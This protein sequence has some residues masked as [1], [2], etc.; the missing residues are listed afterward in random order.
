MIKS[1]LSGAELSAR[2]SFSVLCYLPQRWRVIRIL[3]QVNFLTLQMGK[4][5]PERGR[6]LPKTPQ[7]IQ[8][9]NPDFPTPRKLKGVRRG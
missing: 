8:S 1:Y 7:L 6:E 5:R 2:L 3:R 9:S 4:L